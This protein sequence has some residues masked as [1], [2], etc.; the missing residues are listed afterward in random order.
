LNDLGHYKTQIKP[1]LVT[2]G[3]VSPVAVNRVDG[4]VGGELD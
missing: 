3:L 1:R 2:S 4:D